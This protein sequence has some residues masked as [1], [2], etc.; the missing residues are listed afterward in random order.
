MEVSSRYLIGIDLGT[1]NSAVAYVDTEELPARGDAPPVRVFEVP[2]LV[3]EGEVRLLPALPSFL[4]FVP[5]NG[6]E[7]GGTRLPWEEGPQATVVGVMAREQGALVPGRQVSSAKSWLC[8]SSV[9]RT[10]RILPWS[11]EQ[12][13]DSCSP[14]EAA[15]RYLSHLRDAWNY[16]MAASETK[17]VRAELRFERQTIVLT[18]PA[19]FDE[20]A[21][22]LT[23]S[24]AREAGLENLTLLE[25]PLAA[26]YSWIAAHRTSL[27]RYVKDGQLV[28]ICD[29]GGGT[30]DFSLIRVRIS[31][32]EV[33]FTRT[34]IGE[35]LLLGGDNLDLALERLV[36]EKL[37][38]PRLSLRQQNALRR[39]CCAAKERLLSDARTERV[40]VTV[41]GGGRSLI[42]GALTTELTRAEVTSILAEGFL[43]LTAPGDLPAR[44]RRV[45]L[46]EFGLPYAS[47]AA[48]TRHLAAFLKQAA[49]AMSA[50]ASGAQQESESP[51]AEAQRL[52]SNAEMVR[53]DA[54]LFNGG[55]FH[56]AIARERVAQAIGNWFS[57]AGE[58]QW[59]PKVLTNKAAESAVALGAAYYAQARRGGGLRISGGSARGYYIGVQQAAV[60]GQAASERRVVAVCVLPRGTEEGTRIELSEREFTVLTNRPVSFT[61]YSTTTRH[62]A[63]GAVATFDEDEAH[64]HAP[65]ITVLRYGKRSRHIELNVRLRAYFTEVGT[66]EL[67]CEAPKTGHKWRLQFQLRGRE[68]PEQDEDETQAD[69]TE[70]AQEGPPQVFIPEEGVEAALKLIRSVFG[71]ARGAPEG[72][73]VAPETLTG[74]LESAL[75]YR[76][77]AWPTVT[78]RKLCDA[79]AEVAAGRKKG[80]SYE[81]RWLNLFGFCLRP[82][83]GALLDDWRVAQARKIYH[84][85]L[86]FQKDLQCQ[87]EWLILWRR[88]AGGMNA[89]QQRELYERHK[90]LVGVGARKAK[91][92][93]N[94]Q[95]EQECW[96]LLVGL[97]HLPTGVRVA[98]GEEL[99]SRIEE[100]PDNKGYLWALGRLGA[101]SPLY[102]PLNCVVP[103]EDAG[104]WTGV[105]LE[106]PRLT[107]HAAAAVAQLAALTDNP[108]RDVEP[109]IRR[110]AIER[111]S[112]E[113]DY[114]PL[115]E[116]LKSYVPPSST[117]AARIFG[118][119]LPEGLRLLS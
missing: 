22:E 78:I 98:L 25:E 61:L 30:T 104:R 87:V 6:F 17:A 57:E 71:N 109:E 62:D 50:E 86:S 43:P 14:V 41:L 82:G 5:E 38:H 88:V 91:G 21:R 36:E 4:Y 2:Q 49:T 32:K 105:L 119:S 111:L 18:V 116:G 115:V 12:T 97:E 106:L 47:E 113:A 95:V 59:R 84:E 90:T 102:G 60:P 37:G 114:A 51:G 8:L 48:I 65:L 28:L 92:R 66:L 9:D 103:A 1:T 99:L 110:R 52:R 55:F 56:P 63:Q 11:A 74:R 64:R 33:Q 67:W 100:E 53:P 3:A 39:Q 117:S 29:V 46:R 101:R 35:H 112:T 80:R 58:P 16:R 89:G 107:T 73:A 42:G 69:E 31:G 72:E 93:I 85:G 13:E 45:A 96:L 20:E 81:A 76:K 23:V 34:A 7:S 19:S 94:R 108:L 44:D 15:A 77:D 118:E 26:F 70:L 75:G 54:I 68:A 24:A 27:K 79:L 40:T 83:F 10:A